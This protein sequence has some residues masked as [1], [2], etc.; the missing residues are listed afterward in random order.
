MYISLQP[1]NAKD[2][3]YLINVA[4]FMR[5]VDKENLKARE[6]EVI[7]DAYHKYWFEQG[8]NGILQFHAPEFYLTNGIAQF[9]NGRHRTLLLSRYLDTMPM[10]LTNMDGYPMDEEEPSKRSLDVLNKI[11]IR[12]IEEGEVFEFPDLPIRYLGYDPNIGK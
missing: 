8:E 1:P 3:F 12:E 9:V 4:E 7:R 11:S 2:K 5:I 6:S 10:A